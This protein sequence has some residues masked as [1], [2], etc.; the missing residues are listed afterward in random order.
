MTGE[1]VVNLSESKGFRNEHGGGNSGGGDMTK[2]VTKQELDLEFSKLTNHL[3]NR[4][5]E[6]MTE[7]K[8]LRQDAS[9]N[10]NEVKDQKE[11]F[12]QLKTMLVTAIAIPIVLKIL[13]L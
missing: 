10:Q 13:G 9:Y 6:I 1:K 5:N 12:K 11:D 7:I 3:D 8:L 2:Y 4:H